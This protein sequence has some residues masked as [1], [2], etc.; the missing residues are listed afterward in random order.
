MHS[1]FNLFIQWEGMEIYPNRLRN[2]VTTCLSDNMMSNDIVIRAVYDEEN[3][4]VYMEDGL[5]QVG[6]WFD[7]PN[8]MT[9]TNDVL[10]TEIDQGSSRKRKRMSIQ[11][12]Q[13]LLLP[14]IR[15]RTL[16]TKPHM[17]SFF[18]KL[19]M[20]IECIN[21]HPKMINF[22]HNTNDCV[23]KQQ[24]ERSNSS[25]HHATAAAWAE[26]INVQEVCVIL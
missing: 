20:Y 12:M 4:R 9:D 21:N 19:E 22:L 1:H 18:N 26:F 7:D 8:V 11:Q 13:G 25:L 10:G 15:D 24:V 6:D 2:I 23:K 3:L 5:E 14:S 16:C 17:D